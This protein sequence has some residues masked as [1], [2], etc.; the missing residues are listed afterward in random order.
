MMTI[1]HTKLRI[2]IRKEYKYKPETED[3]KGNILSRN[4]TRDFGE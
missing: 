3:G 4:Q 1:A 2:A